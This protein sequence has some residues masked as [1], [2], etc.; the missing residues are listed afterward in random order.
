MTKK[1]KIMD[2]DKL[3]EETEKLL[4]LLQDRQRGL[5]TWNMFLEERLKNIVNLAAEGGITPTS[6]VKTEWRE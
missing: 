1:R 2:L 5:M 3:Q 4:V 6:G